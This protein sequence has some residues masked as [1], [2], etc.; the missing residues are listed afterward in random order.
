[1]K[2]QFVGRLATQRAYRFLIGLISQTIK[3]SLIICRRN[4]P[5]KYFVDYRRVKNL[6]TQTIIVKKSDAVNL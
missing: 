6:Y 5:H 1:M 3:T 2:P 4:A